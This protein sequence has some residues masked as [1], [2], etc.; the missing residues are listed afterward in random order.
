MKKKDQ[1]IKLKTNNF[2]YKKK[3]KHKKNKKKIKTEVEKKN[4]FIILKK[5]KRK[6]K[7][8]RKKTPSMINH[9]ITVDTASSI[10]PSHQQ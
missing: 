1:G 6:R 3:I 5:E 9:L 10:A 7:R 4:Q 8:K 2:F